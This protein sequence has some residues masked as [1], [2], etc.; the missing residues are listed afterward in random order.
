V[1]RRRRISTNPNWGLYFTSRV[2]WIAIIGKE[3]SLHKEHGDTWIDACVLVFVDS[4]LMPWWS[5]WSGTM[6]DHNCSHSHVGLL[7][8]WCDILVLLCY[9]QNDSTQDKAGSSCIG[10][11]E[12]FWGYSCSI[13]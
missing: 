7:C 4:L 10:A 12:G 1:R 6:C 5:W 3:I 8:F 2:F 9:L 13:W 11:T